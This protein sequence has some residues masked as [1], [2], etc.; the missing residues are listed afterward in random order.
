MLG[1]ALSKTLLLGVIYLKLYAFIQ[2]YAYYTSIQGE[3]KLH[4][5]L[6]DLADQTG[7]R[8][9]FVFKSVSHP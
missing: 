8:T 6:P 9:P 1:M 5:F 7:L 2:L 4:P 3:F